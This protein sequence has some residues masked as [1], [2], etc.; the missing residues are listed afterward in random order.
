MCSCNVNIRRVVY[1]HVKNTIDDSHCQP[2]ADRRFVLGWVTTRPNY[3][4]NSIDDSQLQTA[5]SSSELVMIRDHMLELSG[6]VDCSR[7][8]LEQLVDV[9]CTY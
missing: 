1:N 3:L 6:E 4:N 8:V 5:V 7:D 9:V 2:A